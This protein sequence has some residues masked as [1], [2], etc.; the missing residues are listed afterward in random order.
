MQIKAPACDACARHL[1]MGFAAAV[2]VAMP[3]AAAAQGGAF[4][5]DDLAAERALERAL[6]QTGSVL[7]PPR[8]FEIVPFYSY[9][10]SENDTVGPIATENGVA[11]GTSIQERANDSS[12]GVILR[13]GLPWSAQVDVTLP[14][15]YNQTE[16]RDRVPSTVFDVD[17]Q[18]RSGFGDISFSYTQGLRQEGGGLP[19]VLASVSWDTDTGQEVD[20]TSV[21]SGFQEL[22]VDLTATLGQD[23]LVFSGRIGYEHSLEKNNIQPGDTFSFDAGAFLAVNPQTSF[24]FGFSVSHQQEVEVSGTAIDGSDQLAASL[25]LGVATVLRRNVLLA[26]TLGVGLTEDAPDFTV[27]VSL[28]LSFNL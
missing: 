17:S 14:Y 13:A 27:S 26:T 15:V 1:F 19:S 4:E 21:G 8:S 2:I 22:G 7:L 10:R 6:V 23:P 11:V 16:E 3:G 18:T 20:G 12:A 5:I 24:Q 9:A 25:A 28:P